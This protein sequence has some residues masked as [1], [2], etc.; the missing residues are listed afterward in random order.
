M[1]WNDV[2]DFGTGEWKRISNTS[3]T[4]VCPAGGRHDLHQDV[5]HPHWRTL[6][7]SLPTSEGVS[8][9]LW[10]AGIARGPEKN[11]VCL[12]IVRRRT[13]SDPRRTR[14]SSEARRIDRGP[15]CSTGDAGNAERGSTIPLRP[16]QFRQRK[17]RIVGERRPGHTHRGHPPAVVGHHT[18]R[19]TRPPLGRGGGPGRC[20]PD[21]TTIRRILRSPRR[22]HDRSSRC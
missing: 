3:W 22:Q 10:P 2:S 6:C 11:G 16:R 13:V 9:L 17:H 7:R 8:F 21:R 14:A 5:T 15:D 19:R 12:F 4:G 18:G 1:R 20:N